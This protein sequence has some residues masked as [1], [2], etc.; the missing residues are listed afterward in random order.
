MSCLHF[1]SVPILRDEMIVT[2]RREFF[3]GSSF[4]GDK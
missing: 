1:L 4:R 3:W 2:S